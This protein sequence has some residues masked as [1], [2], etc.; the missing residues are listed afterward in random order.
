MTASWVERLRSELGLLGVHQVWG[1][2]PAW[3]FWFDDNPGAYCLEVVLASGI[4]KDDH[5]RIRA[6]LGVKYY[7]TLGDGFF[8]NFS[9]LEGQLLREP[10]FDE[11]GTPDFDHRHLIP[12]NLFN[13]G[14]MELEFSP[15]EDW[16]LYTLTALDHCRK[17]FKSEDLEKVSENPEHNIPGWHLTFILYERLLSLHAF[18]YKQIPVHV[19]FGS[20]P[21]FETV[22][23]ADGQWEVRDCKSSNA[24]SMSILFCP[25]HS[26]PP[27][28]L[29]DFHRNQLQQCGC[30]KIVDHT[31][32]CPHFH[33]LN[34]SVGG[35][36]VLSRNWWRMAE[37]DYKSRL[38]SACGCHS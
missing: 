26:V 9:E 38:A 6:I 7:P 27:N 13:V 23:D 11:T 33:D 31:F 22:F 35:S 37:V 25:K 12:D 19:Q 1:D 36:K 16:F 15:E 4:A 29:F 21:G 14:V 18:H 3:Y 2:M 8:E 30:W 20:A 10:C 32:T 34:I 5:D 28:W 24:F 17:L